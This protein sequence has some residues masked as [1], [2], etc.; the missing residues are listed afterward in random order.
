MGGTIEFIDFEEDL[1]VR[2][3]AYLLKRGYLLA[4]I[5]GIKISSLDRIVNPELIGILLGEPKIKRHFFGK[6]RREYVGLFRLNNKYSWRLEIYGREHVERFKDLAKQIA[7][8]F[9]TKIIISLE[10][11]SPKVEAF[12][13]DYNY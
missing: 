6:K 7:D 13:S 3:G 8:E 10:K 1:S 11:E 2:V 4:D 12:N 5:L 9:N